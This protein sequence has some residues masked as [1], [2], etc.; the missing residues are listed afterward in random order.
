VRKVLVVFALACWPLAASAADVSDLIKK[1]GSNDNEVRRSAAKEL[2]ELGKEAAPA[3]KALITALKD[4]DGFVRRFSAQALGKIGP[5][6]SSA[7][8]A[9]GTLLNDGKQ[10]IRKAAV[11]ALGNMG[12]AAVPVLSK[13]LKGASSDVQELAIPALGK[14]GPDGLPALIGVIK[15]AKIDASLR[16][17]AIGAVVPMGKEAHSAVPTLAEVV[18]K[19]NAKGREAGQF[20]LDAINALGNLATKEDSTAIAALDSIVNNEKERNKQ[21]KNQCRQAL[22]KINARE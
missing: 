19:P 11:Q 22:K 21:L 4:D 6:A 13:A 17:M 10:P 16:R 15:D 18:K 1:L 5:E 9:L 2:G 8:N 7:A 14:A 12:S 20:R 3:V